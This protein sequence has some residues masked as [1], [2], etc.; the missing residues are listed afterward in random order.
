MNIQHMSDKMGMTYTQACQDVYS[1]LYDILHLHF[2][3]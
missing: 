1:L 2:L 3:R